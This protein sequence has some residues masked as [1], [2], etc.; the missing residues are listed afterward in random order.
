MIQKRRFW[1]EGSAAV[2]LS[3]LAVFAMRWDAMQLPFF[4]DEGYYAIFSRAFHDLGFSV[5]SS[6]DIAFYWYHPPLYFAFLGGL[7]RLVGWSHFTVHLT[8]LVVASALIS[9][10]YLL[11]RLHA[12]RVI[13]A[14]AALAVLFSPVFLSEAGLVQA[15][16]SAAVLAI[17]SLYFFFKNKRAVASGLFALGVLA[18]ATLIVTAGAFAAALFW[19]HRRKPKLAA[20]E[21]FFFLLPA[22]IGVALWLVYQQG[23][24]NVGWG[25]YS[26][27][28]SVDHFFRNGLFAVLNR[29]AHRVFQIFFLDGRAI[30]TVAIFAMFYRR[31]KNRVL[32]K[33]LSETEVACFALLVIETVF[34]SIF[35]ATHQ[36]YFLV[37]LPPLFI[38]AAWSMRESVAQVALLIAAVAGLGCWYLP[39]NK[40]TGFEYRNSYR[41]YVRLTQT[42]ASWIETTYPQSVIA[43]PWPISDALTNSQLGYVSAPLLL[44]KEGK[45][46]VNIVFHR[47]GTEI[48]GLDAACRRFT[49]GD[50]IARICINY[51]G[52]T[53]PKFSQ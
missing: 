18:N 15:D 37:A 5:R 20:K 49:Q 28:E 51:D 2:L 47:T 42:V 35:G 46:E 53:K 11:A 43:A 9:G 34:L 19:R 33:Q 25:A 27:Q 38:L 10:T 21:I 44:T 36:R 26:K 16:L 39:P 14:L 6:K 23:A 32:L 24:A 1:G 22:A 17:W 4:W 45:G 7:T 48:A 29:F 3:L 50:W 13:A 30:A 8:N 41:N 40:Y 12:S 31:I 52:S